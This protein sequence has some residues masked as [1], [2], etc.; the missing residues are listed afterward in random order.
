MT[1]RT[2]CINEEFKKMN[3]YQNTTTTI[4]G[5]NFMAENQN[6]DN[7]FPGD[8]E[9]TATNDEGDMFLP[10][11]DD[12]YEETCLP[13]GTTAELRI[14]H[15]KEGQDKHGA[16]DRRFMLEIV[17]MPYAKPI[18]YYIGLPG[19]NDN[20]RTKNQK[21]LR[22]RKFLAAFGIP[23]GMPFSWKA[24]QGETAWAILSY[25]PEGEYPDKNEVKQWV[26]PK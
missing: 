4:K 8:F 15:V 12:T 9:M 26:S 16:P 21:N 13:T 18:N 19:P 7:N 2:S 17:D 6:T 24:L 10:D 20:P 25:V 14:I 1:N 22:L 3:A 23:E 11:F 5:E